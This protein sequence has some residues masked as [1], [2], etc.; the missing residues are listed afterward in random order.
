MRAPTFEAPIRNAPPGYRTAFCNRC[1]SPVPDVDSETRWFEMPIPRTFT[2]TEVL[3]W[4]AGLV[5]FFGIL[6]SLLALEL[7][8]SS[9]Y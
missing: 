8:L 5:A 3:R 4:L 1:G 6:S 2:I 7:S 9:A